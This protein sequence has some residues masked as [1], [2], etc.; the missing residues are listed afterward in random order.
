MIEESVQVRRLPIRLEPDRRRTIARF[1]WPGAEL[2]FGE[3]YF[4]VGMVVALSTLAVVVL[5]TFTG[6][7]LPFLLRRLGF[8]PA[9]ASGPFVMTVVDVGGIFVYLGIAILILRGTLL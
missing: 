2:S 7:M 3:Y 5:G 1:F 4:S 8:D 9:A 6:S